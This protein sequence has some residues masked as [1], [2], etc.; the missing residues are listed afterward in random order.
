MADRHPNAPNTGQVCIGCLP[1]TFAAE[2]LKEEQWIGRLISSLSDSS[3]SWWQQIIG[4]SP[5]TYCL[6]ALVSS[7][8]SYVCSLLSL[9]HVSFAMLNSAL[10]FLLQISSS[11]F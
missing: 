11:M 4:Q 6:A 7:D 9:W 2:Y 1:A 10:H 5:W 8:K 3:F